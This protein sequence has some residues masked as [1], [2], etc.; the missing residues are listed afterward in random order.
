[1]S[2][3]FISS[4]LPIAHRFRRNI[5]SCSVIVRIE[6]K[7]IRPYLPVVTCMDANMYHFQVPKV[8]LQAATVKANISRDLASRVGLCEGGQSSQHQEFSPGTR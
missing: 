4:L 2:G 1:M 6:E 3:G 5:I 8:A 7:K